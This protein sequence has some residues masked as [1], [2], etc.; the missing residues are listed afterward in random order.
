[1]TSA[2]APAGYG[3]GRPPSRYSA[4]QL[5]A[6]E[7][8]QMLAADLRHPKPAPLHREHAAGRQGLADALR[9][10]AELHALL[11]QPPARIACGEGVVRALPLHP[12]AGGQHPVHLGGRGRQPLD[13]L[14]EAAEA[15]VSGPGARPPIPREV[16]RRARRRAGQS[17]LEPIHH[18]ADERPRR[19][20]PRR[21]VGPDRAS[22]APARPPCPPR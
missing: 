20:R 6:H 14:A 17:I 10:I 19:P 4:D 1:M 9:R 12:E 8:S 11:G 5:A 15:E 22:P 18:L 13:E 21:P 7:L 3:Q 2:W 16:R